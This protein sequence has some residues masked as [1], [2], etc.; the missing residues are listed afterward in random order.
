MV[1]LISHPCILGSK[2]KT[3]LKI[4]GGSC[5]SRKICSRLRSRPWPSCKRFASTTKKD[6]GPDSV[7]ADAPV[8]E[9][10]GHGNGNSDITDY[11][12]SS[13]IGRAY[14]SAQPAAE[15]HRPADDG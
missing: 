15:R 10:Y 11:H 13:A 1:R 6:S 8:R 14:F 4:P 2:S 12:R 9:N 5:E 3:F 7:A